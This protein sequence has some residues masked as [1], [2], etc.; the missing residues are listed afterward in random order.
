MGDYYIAVTYLLA[1]LLGLCVGSFLNVVIYRLPNGMSL[2][3]PPS[4]CPRCGYRLKWYDNIPVLSYLILGGKCRSCKA[5]ISFR[6]TAVELLNA[7]LWLASVFLFWGKSIPYAIL[8]ALVFS[9]YLCVFFIDLSHHLIPDRFQIMLLV[10]GAIAI[11][12]DPHAVWYSHL[13]GGAVGFLSFFLI[14]FLFKRITGKD[15]LGFGDVKLAGTAGLLLGWERFLLGVLL[16]ALSAAVVMLTLRAV[17]SRKKPVARKPVPDTEDEPEGAFPFGPF[18]VCGFSV[19]LVFGN[20]ILRWYLSL[21][22][23]A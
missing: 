14:A 4:H 7:V 15:G 11:L 19:A 17:R 12:F 9:I 10:L 3:R 13:I 6:Y 18:L 20:A 21:L 5:H 22:G 1:G 16:A 2:S 23:V 8:T